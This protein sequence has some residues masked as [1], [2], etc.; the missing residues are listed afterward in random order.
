MDNNLHPLKQSGLPKSL[1][2]FLLGLLICFPAL[3]FDKGAPTPPPGNGPV[4]LSV[5]IHINNI[6]NIN[7]VHETYQIDG[8]L[9]YRWKDERMGYTPDSVGSGP[10]IYINDK[11]R[12]LIATKLWFPTCEFINVQGSRESPNIRI[13]ISPDGNILYTERFFETFIANMNYKS[14]PFDTQSFNIIMEPWG[15]NNKGIVFTQHQLFPKLEES[16]QII[17]KWVVDTLYSKTDMKVYGHLG[18]ADPESRTWSR[19][20]FE[21]RAKRMSGYFIWQVMFPLLIIIMASFVIF[22]ITEFA[23][24]IGI[25][26]TLMLT[27]VAFNFYSASILPKLPY[28]TFIESIIMVG[29]VFIFLGIIAVILNYKLNS[30]QKKTKKNG[31]LKM[32]RYLFPLAFLISMYVLYLKFNA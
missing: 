24:Q 31:L 27:V 29:Y 23:T 5:S 20:V 21:V 18:T 26:F 8:Y 16:T 32:L 1:I 2:N 13:E 10:R 14:F 9:V 6:Y 3:A 4:G 17:D 28:N 11:A 25:G 22:W 7:T 30:K 12:E 15:Y 19:V